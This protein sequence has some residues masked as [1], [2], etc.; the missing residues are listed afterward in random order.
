MTSSGIVDIV[1]SDPDFAVA[2]LIALQRAGRVSR[3]HCAVS[4]VVGEE[5]S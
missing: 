5:S 1:F 2:Q 3:E 4:C